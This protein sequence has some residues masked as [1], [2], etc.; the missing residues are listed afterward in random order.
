MGH[1]SSSCQGIL[2]KRNQCQPGRTEFS[3]L[4]SYFFPDQTIAPTD[5]IN[6]PYSGIFILWSS[7]AARYLGPLLLEDLT[8]GSSQNS[9]LL[10]SYHFSKKETLGYPEQIR[11]SSK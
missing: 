9:S 7:S 10:H 5:T 2:D 8:A 1:T 11:L 3:N 4:R 6:F